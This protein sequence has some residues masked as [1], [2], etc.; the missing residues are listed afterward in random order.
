MVIADCWPPPPG[1]DARLLFALLSTR[2]TQSSRAQIG[3]LLG[4]TAPGALRVIR[5]GERRQTTDAGF[6]KLLLDVEQLLSVKG[7]GRNRN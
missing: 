1:S 2:H 7:S 5:S 4:I 6:A 3:R